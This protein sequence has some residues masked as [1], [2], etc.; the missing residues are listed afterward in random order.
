MKNRPKAFSSQYF[1]IFVGVNL[2]HILVDMATLRQ[3]ALAMVQSR[4]RVK[5]EAPA[6]KISDFFWYKR[7]WFEPNEAI[8]CTFCI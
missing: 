3:Q 6:L 1:P 4:P 8:P 7:F 5:V 2:N